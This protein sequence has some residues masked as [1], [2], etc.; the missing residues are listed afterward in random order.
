M[1]LSLLSSRQLAQAL[2]GRRKALAITQAIAGA[3]VGLLPK[4]VSALESDPGSCTVSSLFKL[5]SALDLEI[6]LRPKA[7]GNRNPEGEW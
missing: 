2:K 5:L 1:E 3:K 7:K 6:V 4:T